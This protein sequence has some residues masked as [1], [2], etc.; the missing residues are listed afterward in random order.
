MKIVMIS[1]QESKSG[2]KLRLV[3]FGNTDIH[4]KNLLLSQGLT[5]DSLVTVVRKA[6]L[7]CPVQLQVRGSNVMLRVQEAKNLQWE[8]I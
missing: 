3:S 8:R 2:D 6:P 7:G 1:L 4:Y 5:Q